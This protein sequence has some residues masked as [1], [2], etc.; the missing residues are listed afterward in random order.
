MGL[1]LDL[2][3]S[4]LHC[5]WRLSYEIA[6]RVLECLGPIYPRDWEL[7]VAEISIVYSFT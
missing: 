6:R 2:L 5:G 1:K 3:L 4:G 7:T